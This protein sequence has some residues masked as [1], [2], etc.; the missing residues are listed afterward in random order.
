MKR[1]ILASTMLVMVS[2]CDKSQATTVTNDKIT[3]LMSFFIT[4]TGAGDGANLG[5]IEGADEHCQNLADDVDAGNKTWRAYLSTTGRL[6]RENA[7][8]NSAS[9][10]ARDRIG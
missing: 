9:V 2:A 4:S 6:D 7:E 5:G 1:I 3:G 8:N 10:H